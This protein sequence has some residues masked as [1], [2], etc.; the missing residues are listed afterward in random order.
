[1]LLYSFFDKNCKT[2]NVSPLI[3]IF[4]NVLKVGYVKSAQYGKAE[5]L[6]YESF[7]DKVRL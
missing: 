1:M 5:N 7:P 2:P 3:S 6:P 4:P